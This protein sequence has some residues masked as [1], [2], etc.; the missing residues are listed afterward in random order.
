MLTALLTLAFPAMALAADAPKIDT[1]DTALVLVSAGLVML[2]T[3]GLA[4]FY[5]GLVRAKNVVHTMILSIACMAL[6]G[7]L[8]ALV[9]YTLAFSPGGSVNAFIGGLSWAGLRGVGADPAADLAATVPHTA[10]M[11]F[12]GMFALITP[13]LISGAIVERVRLKAYLV[14]VA[15]WS[16][17]VYS[18]VA[19]WVWAPGGWLRNLGALDFAGGTVVH[20]NAAAAAVVFAMVL[21]KRRG[22]KH[23][24]VLPHSVPFVVLGAGLLW[25]GWLG[26]NGGSA[27]AANGVAAYAFANT[28]FAPA[29]AALAWGL[30]ELVYFHGKMSGV[31]VASGAVAGLVAITPAAGFVTPLAS[32]LIGGVAGILSLLAVRARPSLGL[33]DSLD[34]FAV[35]GVAATFGALAT[36]VLATTAVNSAGAN[37]S[38]RQLGIQA[39]GVVVTLAWSAG[40]S[41]AIL[42]VVAAL[43][44]LRADEQDEW[45][46]MDSS[47]SGERGYITA[48]SDGGGMITPAGMA[49]APL[50]APIPVSSTR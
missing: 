14:F 50:S 47:E 24:T 49:H 1:G 12:Q 28:F 16:V 4:F 37:G 27:L 13:A 43:T 15:L 9:G 30:A 2:M 21:G 19:H 29:A 17:V 5:G 45:S 41:W 42:K 3:P 40:L 7:V 32:L 8:W 6:V 26:F 18:P 34:V 33:D 10:F 39:V 23:P 31:G 46:G 35:H 38:L 25:F 22:L 11:L 44:P 20:I 36:G 48:D